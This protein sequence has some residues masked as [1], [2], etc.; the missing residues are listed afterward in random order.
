MGLTYFWGAINCSIAT[1][2]VKVKQYA[3][4]RLY[5]GVTS[6]LMQ[7]GNRRTYTVGIAL[8]KEMLCACMALHV[9]HMKVKL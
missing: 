8:E 6:P 3:L 4:Q 5:S 1:I 9:Q 7:L 2:R